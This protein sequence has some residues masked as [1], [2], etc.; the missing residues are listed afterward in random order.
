MSVDPV[1]GVLAEPDGSLNED[2]IERSMRKQLLHRHAS[3][4]GLPIWPNWPF[5]DPLGAD[6]EA[7]MKYMATYACI[8]KKIH[9]ADR[10]YVLMG[11]LDEPNEPRS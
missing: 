9:C 1:Y 4:I 11:D 10:G 7:A 6:R 8:L 2:K 5:K 3:T